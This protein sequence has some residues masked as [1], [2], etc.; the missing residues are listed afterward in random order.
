MKMTDAFLP[1][2]QLC[3]SHN[4]FY[5]QEGVTLDAVSRVAEE[6]FFRG[7]GLFDIPDKS[8]RKQIGQ[9][10]QSNNLVVTWWTG[11]LFW[12]SDEALDP[13]SLDENLRKKTVA[14]IKE[15]LE[16]LAELGTNYLGLVSGSSAGAETCAEAMEQ[17]SITACE[18]CEAAEPFDVEIVLEALDRG[19][20]KDF[21]FGPTDEAV[22]LIQKVRKSYSNVSLCWDSSHIAL[23]GEDIIESLIAMGPYLSQFHFANPVLDKSRTDFGDHHIPMGPPGA[24]TIEKMAEVYHKAIQHEIFGKRK[25]LVT[26]E[27]RASKEDDPWSIAELTKNTLV[28]AWDLYEKE[29]AKV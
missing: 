28:E 6:G 12:T 26:A 21:V 13:S 17:F 24:L 14:A 9:I 11:Y 2:L 15:I 16:P 4:H 19:A 23:N 1:H 10:V 25:P 22:K 3:E 5:G 27:I 7:V 29:Y 8:S 20:H 18:L